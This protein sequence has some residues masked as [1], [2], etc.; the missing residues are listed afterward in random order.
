MPDDGAGPV[1]PGVWRELGLTD[2]EWEQICDILGRVPNWTELGMYS[3]LWSE[4]CAYKH[5]RHLFHLFPTEGERILQGVGENAGVVDIGD[6]WAVTFK[7]ESHNSPTAVDPYNGAATGVGGILR[8]VFTM[9]ARPIALL[10]SLR[11]GPLDTPHVRRLF[12]GAVLGMSGYGNA[13]GVPTVG[14]EVEFDPSFSGNPLVNVMAVGLVRHDLVATASAKGVG[15]P[16]LVV[17]APTGRDGIQGASFSSAELELDFKAKRPSVQVG[18]PFIG[19]LLVEACLELIA[20]GIVVGIQDM[21][22]AGL[23]SSSAE[24]AARAG[25]GIEMDLSKVPRRE[26]GMTPFEIM[27]SE[28]QERM[29]VV[30]KKGEENK[31]VD[32]FDKWGLEAVVVGKV[33]DD[34]MLR[35]FEGER[36]VAEVPA[37]SLS[38][39]GAPSYI[40]QAKRP[41]Y[42]D[43][44]ARSPLPPDLSG[45]VSHTLLHM[46]KDPNIAD[47]SWA[48][49]QFDH[50]VQDR[51]IAGPG[52]ADAAVLR[53][54]EN[55]KSLALTVDC[56]SLHCYIDP[57]VGAQ[58]AVAE[59]A[60]N[61]SCV[62]ALPLAMTDGLN[63]GN[64]EKPEIYWQIEQSVKGI[65]KAAKA[66]STPVIGGNVSLYNERG[67][68]AVKPTPVI[69][70]VGLLEE[71]D[72]LVTPAFEK[73]GDLI[74][75]L[76]PFDDDLGGS[77]YLMSLHQ[78]AKGPLPDL[79]LDVELAVQKAC[80][81][82][83]QQGLVQ[84]A[85]DCSEGG[86]AVALAESALYMGIGAHVQIPRGAGED[87]PRIDGLL[88]GEGYSRIMVGISPQDQARA[89]KFLQEARVP[90]IMIGQTKGDTLRIDVRNKN[91]QLDAWVDLPLTEM[92]KAWFGALPQAM[93]SN[94]ASLEHFA[95]RWYVN[96]QAGGERL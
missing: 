68:T 24:M 63:F 48:Y 21:G 46:L 15:N 39:E 93:D 36:L 4:H 51:T 53:L 83:I 23:T 86:L 88:Y 50:D 30:A 80:R 85:H 91:D 14:G 33:T 58:A 72:H 87:G 78:T 95:P 74:Y 62:G 89:E 47:K 61:L 82:L 43:Q 38:S 5:S 64:P 81:S 40:P 60:R 55:E 73:E 13:V 65:A 75:L 45:D 22:A 6:G 16:V 8:D 20:S 96:R 3:V 41:D 29:L 57:F 56:N 70:M 18:N 1:Q 10:N 94:K 9:G 69:G 76:G 67:G 31:V 32:L 17:G 84:F 12:E 77:R 7:V 26:D 66:L 2:S 59:A 52:M 35:L 42:I 44:L 79:D 71:S 34:G 90:W 25:T 28:S 92:A 54:P 27:L 11:F 19:K 49:R 37:G